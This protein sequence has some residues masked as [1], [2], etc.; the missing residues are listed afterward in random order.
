MQ[1]D[2]GPTPMEPFTS[3]EEKGLVDKLELLSVPALESYLASARA[4]LGSQALAATWRTRIESGARHAAQA[5]IK[6]QAAEAHAATLP[7]PAPAV[8]SKSKKAV[9]ASVDEASAQADDEA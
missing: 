2:T 8:A 3:E 9:A 7:P 1:K 4:A 6:A 5:L